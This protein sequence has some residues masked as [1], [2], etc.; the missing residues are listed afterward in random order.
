MQH[1]PLGAGREDPG[2][3]VGEYVKIYFVPVMS[4]T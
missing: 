4:V 1:R 2:D 3:E